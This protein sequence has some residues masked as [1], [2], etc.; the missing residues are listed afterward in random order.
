MNY[1]IIVNSLI[2]KVVNSKVEKKLESKMF[3]HIFYVCCMLYNQAQG[4]E[5]S[6]ET[7]IAHISPAEL[8]AYQVSL[9][10]CVIA[11]ETV[12]EKF[13]SKRNSQFDNLF[14]C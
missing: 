2:T 13:A 6:L 12:D 1:I 4:V 7:K 8:H 9:A 3:W 5:I 10:P 14:F 11:S